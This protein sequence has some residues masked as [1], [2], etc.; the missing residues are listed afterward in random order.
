MTPT[1]TPI[2]D[3]A[4]PERRPAVWPWLLVPL[5]ALVIFF[6]LR[7]FRDTDTRVP[8]PVQPAQVEPATSN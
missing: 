6:V 5:V 3:A 2:E 1:P 4:P 8:E 7:T